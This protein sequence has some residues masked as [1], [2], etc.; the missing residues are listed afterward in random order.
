[1]IDCRG[2]GGERPPDA[3]VP[4]ADE[5]HR[6]VDK[7]VDVTVRMR[8]QVSDVQVVQRHFRSSTDQVV[9]ITLEVRHIKFIDRAVDIPV[10]YQRQVL[11]GAIRGTGC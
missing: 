10:V 9:Q 1:M 7:V 8:E 3:T 2:V 5:C 11:T 4:G 6:L